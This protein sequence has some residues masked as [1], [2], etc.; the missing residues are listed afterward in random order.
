MKYD[1][2]QAVGYKTVS[3]SGVVSIKIASVVSIT[4][5]ETADQEETFGFPIG[6]V[7]YRVEFGDGSDILV[8]EQ[9]LDGI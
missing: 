9:E 4:P 7:M 2:G 1:Y 6:T 3:E 5:V 8:P